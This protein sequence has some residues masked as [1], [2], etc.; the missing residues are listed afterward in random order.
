MRN[1]LPIFGIL[2]IVVF[3]IC[4][5]CAMDSSNPVDPEESISDDNYIPLLQRETT[6]NLSVEEIV[7]NIEKE[8]VELIT[9]WTISD[10]VFEFKHE[11]VETVALAVYEWIE[12]LAEAGIVDSCTYNETG[13]SVSFTLENSGVFFYVPAETGTMSGTD[14]YGVMSVDTTLVSYLVHEI[15]VHI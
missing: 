9:P 2:F 4:S 5:I 6:K 12:K 10:G 1:Y 14:E 8:L 13:S 3:Y 7:E 15:M 11:D